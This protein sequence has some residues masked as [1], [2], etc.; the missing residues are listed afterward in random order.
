MGQIHPDVQDFFRASANL[1]PLLKP[2]LHDFSVTWAAK[3][4][5]FG[6]EVSAFFL[7]PEPHL[8][9]TFGIDREVLLLHAPYSKVEARLFQVAAWILAELPA[10]GRVES[11][12]YL[13]IGPAGNLKQAVGQQITDNKQARIAVPF[14]ES[15][16]LAA[17]DSFFIRNRMQEYLFT[18]DLFDLQLP[19][20]S[21]TYYF[22][23]KSLLVDLRDAV[24]NGE[25][26]GVF[27]LR[28]TGK[29][30][31]LFKLQRDLELERLANLIY[32]DLQD[33]ALYGLRWWELLDVLRGRLPAPKGPKVSSESTAS[34]YFRESVAALKGDPPPRFVFALDE[35]EHIAP[36]L[37]MRQHWDMDFLEL[38]KTLRAIQNEHRQVSFVVAGVNSSV[39]ETPT[40]EGHDNPLFSM[41]RVRYMP[42]FER[43]EIRQLIRT[44]GWPMGLRFDEDTYE[45]L[46]R[47][48]G[49]H[50]LLTRLACSYAHKEAGEAAS[51]P[52]KVSRYGLQASEA[53]R[54]SSLFSFGNH[55]LGMLKQWYP[56]EYQMLGVLARGDV[57]FYMGMAGLSPQYAQHLNAYGLV[58][59]NPP[60]ITIPLLA[61]YLRTE[62]TPASKAGPDATVSGA[63]PD[64]L[65]EVGWLRNRLE[66]KLRRFVKRSLKAQL[67]TERWIDPILKAMPTQQ[68]ERLQG[69]DKDE[70][71][72]ERLLLLDLVQ[73]IDQNWNTAFKVLEAAPPAR[74]VTK[75]QV[76]VLLEFV[77]AHREDA[78]A[79]LVSEQEVVALRL[80]VSAIENAVDLYL[81]D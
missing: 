78:H 64:F 11:I 68:R 33:S 76:K 46:Q 59:G 22:G 45:Y 69:V 7:K 9:E 34:R 43:D 10:A 32:L 1:G 75:E 50:P 38:W 81:E 3:R 72:S 58:R 53:S 13:V 21:E 61:D 23:R 65:A 74:R 70:V 24:K 40:F 52:K 18:R 57:S 26:A 56:E 63:A 30:S 14:L 4:Q 48:Y 31:L 49:G 28:K 67:G 15:E 2:F 25:N 60:R 36:R 39:V 47:R 79:K 73:V 66:P 12:V 80:A 17:T 27:G 20:T 77:N 54:D 35:I 62:A 5:R 51:R 71:L 37:R 19:I 6:S 55:I 44:L 16:C 29:T 41:V 8:T 42:A